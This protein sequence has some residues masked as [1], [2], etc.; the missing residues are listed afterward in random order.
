M[1]KT[2]RKPCL[3]TTGRH[4]EY[5]KPYYEAARKGVALLL[6]AAVDREGV[7]ATACGEVA[8]LVTI[9]DKGVANNSAD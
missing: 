8:G 7:G 4:P 5:D 3:S 9:A 6:S 2:R 1:R